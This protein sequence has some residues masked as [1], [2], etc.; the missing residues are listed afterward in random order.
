MAIENPFEHQLQADK[1]GNLLSNKGDIT[2]HGYGISSIKKVV[3]KYNG[4]VIIDT[5]DSI[6]SVTVT[7][8]LKEF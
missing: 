2:K 7:M 6:F 1:N 4:D 3:E 5:E 8:N